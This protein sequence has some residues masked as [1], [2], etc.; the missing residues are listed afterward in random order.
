VQK[1]RI[2]RVVR[3]SD[4]IGIRFPKQLIDDLGISKGDWVE[5]SWDGEEI[6][7]RVVKRVKKS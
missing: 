2:V 1:S 6:R 4:S 3:V 5:I 7:I